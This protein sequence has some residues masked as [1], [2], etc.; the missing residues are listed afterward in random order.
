MSRPVARFL[1]VTAA[2]IF[3]FMGCMPAF[4]QDVPQSN[5]TPQSE[6]LRNIRSVTARKIVLMP[7]GDASGQGSALAEFAT[8]V[9]NQAVRQ[10]GITTVPWFKVNKELKSVL[11]GGA[12]SN[13]PYAQAMQY[14]MMM[15]GRGGGAGLASDENMNEL[16]VAGKKLG[17][18]YII[19]PVIMKQSNNTEYKTSINPFGAM[20]GIGAAASTKRQDNAEVDVK[21]DIVSIV[22]EDIIASRTFSGRSA[23]VT[24]D[25]ANRLDGITGMQVFSGASQMD[26]TKVAFYDT[27]DK[28]VELLQDK[29]Q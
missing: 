5:A 12:G 8:E 11:A 19:R 25:R 6:T 16:I 1:P 22:E 24:K 17:A 18:R 20:F 29:T 26:Q 13:N 21:V 9:I 27:I 2:T 10:G 7:V 14:Q 4:S 23:E 15:M 3:T 28:I